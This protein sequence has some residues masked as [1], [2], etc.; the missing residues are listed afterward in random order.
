MFVIVNLEPE[1]LPGTEAEWIPICVRDNLR[2]NLREFLGMS[3]ITD[4]ETESMLKN[5]KAQ[6]K[7]EYALFTKVK[8]TS[9][10]YSVNAEFKGNDGT[11]KTN[12]SSDEYPSA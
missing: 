12:V 10:G 8:K 7:A 5:G 9:G 6:D 11:V 2:L 3:L 4:T 1:N